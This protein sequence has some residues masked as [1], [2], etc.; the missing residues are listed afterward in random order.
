MSEKTATHSNV[1]QAQSCETVKTLDKIK[2]KLR[3]SLIQ[4]LCCPMG[5]TGHDF[6]LANDM[7]GTQFGVNAFLTL[8]KGVGVLIHIPSLQIQYWKH[9]TS[10]LNALG[11]SNLLSMWSKITA[12]FS[13]ISNIRV[14]IEL[15]L[16]TYIAVFVVYLNLLKSSPPSPQKNNNHV[17]HNERRLF[18]EN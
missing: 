15:G 16:S 2:W 18:K 17:H 5:S 11:I 3:A 7:K 14:K 6:N 8:I 4:P 10:F 13:E 9:R 1:R 12:Y